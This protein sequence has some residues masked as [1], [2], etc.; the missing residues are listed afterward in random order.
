MLG[1]VETGSLESLV[2]VVAVV[3]SGVSIYVSLFVRASIGP[4][5]TTVESHAATLEQHRQSQVD[6]YRELRQLGERTVR[7]ET[8]SNLVKALNELT[9]AVKTALSSQGSNH[10]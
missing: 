7:L 8:E 9:D 1:S 4:L 3:A 2:G 10:G 6:V 5:K